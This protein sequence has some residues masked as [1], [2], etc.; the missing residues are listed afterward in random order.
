MYQWHDIGSRPEKN[1]SSHLFSFSFSS[2]TSHYTSLLTDWNNY[3]SSH[4]THSCGIYGRRSSRAWHNPSSYPT[5]SKPFSIGSLIMSAGYDR[6]LFSP[7]TTL[8]NDQRCLRK[9]KRNQSLPHIFPWERWSYGRQKVKDSIAFISG[10]LG[11]KSPFQI[12][13]VGLLVCW[14]DGAYMRLILKFN[15]HDCQFRNKHQIA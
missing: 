4:I 5:W 13:M 2:S 14:L 15:K 1:K 3:R 11:T 10:K 6:G 12:R 8:I 7:L 9:T